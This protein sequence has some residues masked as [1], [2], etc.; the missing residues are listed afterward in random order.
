MSTFASPSEL[1][2]ALYNDGRRAID[3]HRVAKFVHHVTSQAEYEEALHYLPQEL[4][5]TVRTLTKPC[6]NAQRGCQ[7]K[8]LLGL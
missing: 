2:A 6:G 5:E 4:V 3:A 1:A 7:C 8:W